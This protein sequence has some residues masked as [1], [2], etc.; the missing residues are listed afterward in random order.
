MANARLVVRFGGRLLEA[1]AF[2]P[3]LEERTAGQL[4]VA[5]LLMAAGFTDK[6]GTAVPDSDA[7]ARL[8]AGCVPEGSCELRL[9]CQ[10]AP[11][12]PEAP[13]P[14]AARGKSLILDLK[15]RG[16]AQCQSRALGG[17]PCS[18]CLQLASLH[19]LTERWLLQR[20]A[21]AFAASAAAKAADLP[22]VVH[23]RAGRFGEVL[24]QG[25]SRSSTS[26]KSNS[27]TISIILAGNASPS[28]TAI[29]GEHIGQEGP[30]SGSA[31]A[32]IAA[33]A[34]RTEASRRW[35]RCAACRFSLHC[36]EH[37]EALQEELL[38]AAVPAGTC[39]LQLWD[40]LVRLSAEEALKPLADAYRPRSLLLIAKADPLSPPCPG[41]ASC[42]RCA[43]V[44]DLE[45]GVA[46]M[47]RRRHFWK[48]KRPA[49]ALRVL[50]TNCSSSEVCGTCTE[51]PMLTFLRRDCPEEAF[52]LIVSLL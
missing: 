31:G 50:A 36:Q 2:F 3:G 9:W 12:A 29:K 18:H 39:R 28:K 32:A 23:I 40:G 21:A 27:P 24:G 5:V 4:Q 43:Q 45:P 48:N 37:L 49:F 33:F 16:K 20:K 41:P 44:A 1:P 46:A 30:V 35:L 22:L 47:R 51:A 6:A 10:M 38:P 17:E 14:S 7:L 52:R 25:G 26:N 15:R 34:L 42:A 11:L 13:L 8:P 19:E